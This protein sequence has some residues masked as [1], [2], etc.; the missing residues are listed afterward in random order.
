M[1][2]LDLQECVIDS[3]GGLVVLEALLWNESIQELSLCRL[4]LAH[5][6]CARTLAR[7]LTTNTYIQSLDIWGQDNNENDDCTIEPIAHALKQNTTLRSFHLC[8]VKVS[9]VEAIAFGSALKVNSTLRTLYMEGIAIGNLGGKAIAE[10]LKSNSSLVELGVNGSSMGHIGLR[11]LFSSLRVNQT[12]KVLQLGGVTYKKLGRFRPA[13]WKLALQFNVAI[14]CL[15]YS[16]ARDEDATSFEF[17]IQI[18]AFLRKA[19]RNVA[20]GR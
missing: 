1:T 18:S 10:S 15:E 19:A 8:G 12:L 5:P 4:D 11:A 20:R 7:V 17:Y 2:K 16:G 9:D 13:V 14:E 3:E 6:R